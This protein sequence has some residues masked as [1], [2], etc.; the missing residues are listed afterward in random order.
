MNQRSGVAA[1]VSV[2]SLAQD[3]FALTDEQILEIAPEA[4]DVEVFGGE[5]SDRLDPLREDL[6]LLALDAR[7][8]SANDAER[9]NDESS[10]DGLKAVATTANPTANTTAQNAQAD[11]LAIG[12]DVAPTW[13]TERMNDPQHGAEARALW[14]GVRAARKEA[15]A[16]REVF[17]KPEDAR[18]A[19]QR[20]R[21]LDEI[22]RAYFGAAGNS[23]EQTGAS[24][25]QLAAMMMR[26]NP[27]A[28][29]E[30][31]FVGLR[32]LEEAGKQGTGGIQNTNVANA[33]VTTRAD[34]CGTEPSAI[35][36]TNYGSSTDNARNAA[37]AGYATG[38]AILNS[39]TTLNSIS[40]HNGSKRRA[41][42]RTRHL[43]KPPMRIWRVR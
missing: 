42:Q 38:T 18:A 20:A 43:K 35:A 39:I 37:G 5:R 14:D 40:T 22:D 32:A 13:L 34:G 29:R 27:A 25:A 28:F 10:D 6:D 1:A 8:P 4:Q 23:P 21:T 2:E 31:V 16:F 15:S 30:M 41:W 26:E 11:P 19:A 17:A 7:Q 9:H 24:R 3:L 36:R 12:T 33:A